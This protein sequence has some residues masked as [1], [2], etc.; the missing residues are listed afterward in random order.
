[1]TKNYIYGV[2]L[3]GWLKTIKNGTKS[4]IDKNNMAWNLLF[5]FLAYGTKL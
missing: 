5:N 1:M 3:G 4:E 2:E